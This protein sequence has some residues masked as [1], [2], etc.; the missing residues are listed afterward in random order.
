MGNKKQF[1]FFQ[2]FLLIAAAFAMAVIC[3]NTKDVSSTKKEET[4]ITLEETENGN[5]D[6]PEETENGNVDILEEPKEQKEPEYPVVTS[7]SFTKRVEALFAA[8]NIYC[9]FNGKEYLYLNQEG[10]SLTG[11][12]YTWAYAFQEGLAC[13]CKGEKYGFIDR[14]GN[15]AI[16]FEF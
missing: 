12:T 1:I 7:S 3:L 14:E 16:P 6:L 2:A 11:E 8:E 5:V 15:T 10:D 9:I 13:C 4:F